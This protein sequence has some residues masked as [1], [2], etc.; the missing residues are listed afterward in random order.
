MGNIPQQPRQYWGHGGISLGTTKQLP[1]ATGALG[2]ARIQE[3]E[4]RRHRGQGGQKAGEDQK[5]VPSEVVDKSSWGQESRGLGRAAPGM[6]GVGSPGAG[7]AERGRG[8]AGGRARGLRTRGAGGKGRGSHRGGPSHAG[9]AVTGEGREAEGRAGP[10]RGRSGQA[11]RRADLA[12]PGRPAGRAPAPTRA[13]HFECAVSGLPAPSRPAAPGAG[14]ASEAENS[15]RRL[16]RST[17]RYAPGRR[18][19]GGQTGRARPPLPP[20]PL[21]A[22]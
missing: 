15:S 1:R 16:P 6:A 12:G 17:A 14:S 5:A 13:M 9:A 7:E 21:P 8:V 11:D 3:G 2:M 10:V 18:K 20:L 22:A 4:R 19:A